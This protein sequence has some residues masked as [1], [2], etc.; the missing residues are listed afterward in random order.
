L[1][2]GLAADFWRHGSPNGSPNGQPEIFIYQVEHFAE[3]TGP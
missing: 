2:A 1:K 3:G